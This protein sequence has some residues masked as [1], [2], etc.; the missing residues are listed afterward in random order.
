MIKLIH[1][2]L[3]DS[4]FTV[5]I[6]STSSS[7]EY[8]NSGVPRGSVLAPYLFY[9]FLHDFPHTT[10]I[11][12]VILYADDFRIYAHSA[13]PAQAL[14]NVTHHLKL[15]ND[16]YITWGIKINANKSE[17]ICIRM[18]PENVIGQWYHKVKR[19]VQ[20]LME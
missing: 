9:L 6:Q 8:V 7:L 1:S 3:I 14:H 18:R 20:S 10:Q 12:K 16:F 11:S 2:F 4:K 15:I 19:Y 13:S 17:A 5:H